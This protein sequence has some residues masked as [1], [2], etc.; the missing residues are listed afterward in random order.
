M[1]SNMPVTQHEY[2]LS[3]SETVVSKTDLQG[4]ITYVNQDFVNISG[5]SRE[6]L[7]GAPQ[8]IVR[9][10]DMPAEAFAD[11]WRSMKGGHAWTGMVKNR[12]KNG[13]HYWVE[14]NAAP[15]IEGGRMVGYT[16]IRVKPNREQVRAAE[17]AYR[18]IKAG[19]KELRIHHG[20]VVRRAGWRLAA[21]LGRATLQQQIVG[22]G[23]LLALL[24]AWCW[25]APS[26][27][28]GTA[29]PALLGA[30][31]SL[32]FAALVQRGAV[33]PL[34]RLCHDIGEM[35]AGDLSARI[36]MERDDELGHLAQALRV[37]Q[38]N[39]KLLVGQI[40]ESAGMV[41]LGAGEIASGNNDLSARTEA[42]ASALQ[43][44][45]ASVEQ[46]NSTVRQNAD[47]AREANA[48]VRHTAEAAAK[49]G[50]AVGQVVETMQA[51]QAGS[52]KIA[53]I[54]GV[55]DGIAFQTNILALNAAVEAARAGEQGRGFA[56]V[57]S[58][59]RALAQRSAT[60]A[61]EIKTLIQ[62]SVRQVEQGGAMVG[63]AGRTMDDIVAS[64]ARIA[65][66]MGEISHASQEQSAGIAQVNQAIGAI[67]AATQ[68][69]AALVEQSAAAAE[70]MR[71]QSE[72]LGQLVDAFKL[73]A[74]APQRAGVVAAPARRAGPPARQ[75]VHYALR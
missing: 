57:A 67:D 37:L 60:A 26:L 55:V 2:I 31:G 30:A 41:N 49:G 56:V 15:I 59:V 6:E 1:R 33:A 27:P 32:L 61:A 73:V 45:A 13:D 14:A 16:S 43:Q 25:L 7:L 62:G 46:L 9:H 70:A 20:A 71:L 72:H 69:N 10:P 64:V 12:C 35:S 3:D 23:A 66:Y 18:E 28:G 21:L 34:R 8:N 22:G 58:E 40:K 36:H 75:G 52:R 54:I 19:S 50:A 48:L 4:N 51:I 68:Q 47:N 39:V 17:Q 29:P 65:G 42:Q 38:I 11:F 53:E 24:F 74:D 5:F 63:E 44:T